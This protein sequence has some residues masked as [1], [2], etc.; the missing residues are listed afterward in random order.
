MTFILRIAHD[1]D[2][3][4]KPEVAVRFAP[5]WEQAAERA[6]VVYEPVSLGLPFAQHNLAPFVASP[7]RKLAT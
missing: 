1:P 7:F 3:K 2:A 5:I 4:L 6:R